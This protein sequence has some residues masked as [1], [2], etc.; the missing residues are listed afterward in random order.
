MHCVACIPVLMAVIGLTE[1]LAH[2]WPVV[3]T[4]RFMTTAAAYRATLCCWW[5]HVPT[6]I[7]AEHCKTGVMVVVCIRL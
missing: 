3:V 7:H 6:G 5:Q 4:E 2:S 1:C